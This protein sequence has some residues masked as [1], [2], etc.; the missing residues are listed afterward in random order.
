M[1]DLTPI[2]IGLPEKFVSFRP[3][4]DTTAIDLAT[5]DYRFSKLRAPTGSGK[6][7]TYMSMAML[8][9]ARTLILV[10]TKGLQSQL[11][12]D[13][14]EIGATDMRGQ[15]NYRCV[16]LDEHLVG[17]GRPGSGC[18]EGPCHV[19]VFCNLKDEGGCLYY[20][21]Q[22]EAKA[23]EIVVS[24]YAYWMTLGRHQ[25]PY[26]IGE[27]DLIIMDEAHT[28]PEW[29]AGFCTVSLDR[30][31]IKDLLGLD[32]P[33]LNEGVEIWSAWARQAVAAARQ[34]FEDTR[35]GM[36]TSKQ[37]TTKR[38]LRL[39]EISRD[40]GELAKSRHWKAS[41]TP[42]KDARMP[43]L[44][45]D[46][47]GEQ[48]KRGI[49]FSP[50]WAHAYAEPYLFRG[51]SRI[52]LCSATL[53]E[54]T[55]KYLGIHPDE[56]DIH[57]L[58]KGFEPSRRP[59]YYIP[60][61]RVD[62]KMVEGETRMWVG[63]MDRIIGARGDR[64]GIIHTRSYARAEEIMARSKHS[65]RMITHTWQN[66]RDVVKQFKASPE[67]LILLSPSLEEGFDFPGDECRFQIIAKVPFLDNRSPV[68]KARAQSD[69]GYL[70]HMTALAVTQMAGRGMRSAT[71][72]CETFIV[73]DHWGWFSKAAQSE[74]PQWFRNA[75]RRVRRSASLPDPMPLT[76]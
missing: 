24:N 63:K 68:T 71:D 72:W 1:N 55:G 47:V 27:F 5:S 18:N 52:V 48:T 42:Q 36:E 29:L 54:S 11:I 45:T 74:F 12:H 20:A 69:K 2:D 65:D 49:K 44:Q 3:G 40:L 66:L 15:S 56:Y 10:G 39:K 13:F 58:G 7:V 22:D 38:L 21:A 53:S 62:R 64:K 43:G 60:T 51:A 19:G 4:Q 16:A 37:A 32:L 8:M 34:E 59:F 33:P 70:N 61:V 75:W 31:E 14:K 30:R 23:A 50:V 73:D 41:E 9:G 46:W 17:Y 76:S 35:E 26:V 25:D 57:T 6:S 67:P 28:A